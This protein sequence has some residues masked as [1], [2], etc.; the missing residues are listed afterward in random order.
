M[1]RACGGIRMITPK[2]TAKHLSRKA[3]DKNTARPTADAPVSG[4]NHL[5]TTPDRNHFRFFISLILNNLCY[6]FNHSVVIFS[7][8]K[9]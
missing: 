1:L 5:K 7:F 4:I 3:Q 6:I 9:R 2:Q 8:S